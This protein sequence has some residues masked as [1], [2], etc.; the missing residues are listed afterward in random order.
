M[1]AVHGWEM[2]TYEF[3][4]REHALIGA[5]T[6]SDAASGPLKL[7]VFNIAHNTS[8][9][10][11]HWMGL[12]GNLLSLPTL[13]NRRLFRRMN[14][15]KA[16]LD[17]P[18]LPNQIPF[19]QTS[20]E[21]GS[22]VQ[23]QLQASSH[24]IF[25]ILSSAFIPFLELPE[26][27]EVNPTVDWSVWGAKY[28]RLLMCRFGSRLVAQNFHLHG[29][30]LVDYDDRQQQ[31]LYLHEFSPIKLSLPCV[32]QEGICDPC[33][34]CKSSRGAKVFTQKVHAPLPCTVQSLSLRGLELEM[35][36]GS[37]VFCSDDYIAIVSFDSEFLQTDHSQ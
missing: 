8:A 31:L 4:S 22:M 37:M 18:N 21:H 33:Y 17:S 10:D 32:Y 15:Q 27:A 35:G 7:L 20:R 11:R 36:F 29:T 1:K 24:C 2:V 16:P 5:C 13:V 9:T 6:G 34:P 19:F 30:R 14:I 3:L 23:I 26:S 28:T 25:M 12:K